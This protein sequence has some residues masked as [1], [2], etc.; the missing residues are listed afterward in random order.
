VEKRRQN[1]SEIAVPVA[2]V[3][4]QQEVGGLRTRNISLGGVLIEAGDYAPP[5]VGETVTLVFAD[6]GGE[7]RLQGRVTRSGAEGVALVFQE[8]DL[9]DFDF[10]QRLMDRG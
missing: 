7:R 6:G 8:F 9:E 2:L 4:R 10:L 1:R 5:R 3:H